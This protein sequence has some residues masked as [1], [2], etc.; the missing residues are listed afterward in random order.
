MLEVEV[1]EI[2]GE[3]LYFR[4]IFYIIR[5]RLKVVQVIF[6]KK[7]RSGGWFG[8]D[9][10]FENMF[11]ELN[12]VEYEGVSIMGGGGG[13]LVIYRQKYFQNIFFLV[14]VFGVIYEINVLCQLKRKDYY[15][16][17]CKFNSSFWWGKNYLVC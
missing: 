3:L 17:L 11:C 13:V 5:E 1:K 16:N 7:K 10:V 2:K 6:I 15:V 8:N 4:E 12:E 9:F 14:L